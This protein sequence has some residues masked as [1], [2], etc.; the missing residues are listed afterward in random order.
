MEMMLSLLIFIIIFAPM[1]LLCHELG[2]AIVARI[3]HADHMMI[4]TGSGK[5]R[6][7]W[8]IG[9]LK[10]IIRTSIIFPIYTI[11][12]RELVFSTREQMSISLG[13]PLINGLLMCGFIL[14]QLYVFP[15]PSIQLAIAFNAW[16]WIVNC[17]PFKIGQKQS[18]GYTIYK[19]MRQT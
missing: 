19:M 4:V 3:C 14:V 15:H 5:V 18:D 16:L 12:E 10:W 17:I 13:G 1:S 2:H 7:K 9:R 8:T 11:S 6:F